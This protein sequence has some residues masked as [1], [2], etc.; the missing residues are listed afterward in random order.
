MKYSIS[1]LSDQGVLYDR[2]SRIHKGIVFNEKDQVKLR[3]DTNK[4]ELEFNI[5]GRKFV[6]KCKEWLLDP[7]KQFVPF[8]EL[9]RTGDEV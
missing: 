6:H 9:Y 3:I 1:Y 7:K 4:G 2:G 5:E 8:I